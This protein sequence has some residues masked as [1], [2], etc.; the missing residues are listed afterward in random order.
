MNR[1]IWEMRQQMIIIDSFLAQQA[2]SN[3]GYI[4]TSELTWL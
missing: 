3:D 1:I 4:D 2:N